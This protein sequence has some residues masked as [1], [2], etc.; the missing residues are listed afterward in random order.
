MID[1][2]EP[3]TVLFHVDGGR[4]PVL[5]VDELVP[6][7]GVDL[8]PALRAHHV[9]VQVVDVG[10]TAAAVTAVPVPVAPITGVEGASHGELVALVCVVLGTP[11]T[12]TCQHADGLFTKR[13][14][15]VEGL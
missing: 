7:V 5:V 12:V 1:G 2:P 4:V 3:L 6:V 11:D 8:A 9:G 15:Q 14:Y 13:L 10:L